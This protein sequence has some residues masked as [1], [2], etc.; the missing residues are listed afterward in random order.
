MI[1][2]KVLVED[3]SEDMSWEELQKGLETLRIFTEFEKRYGECP[4]VSWLWGFRTAKRWIHE[5]NVFREGVKAG[6]KWAYEW[7]KNSGWLRKEVQM[8]FEQKEKEGE[9]L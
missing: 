4:K 7:I 5:C 3:K 1:E 8:R 2:E 6:E 9:G